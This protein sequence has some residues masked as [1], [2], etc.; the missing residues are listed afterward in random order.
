MGISLNRSNKNLIIIGCYTLL[1]LI[2]TH[3]VTFQLTTHIAG[4]KGEDNLQWRWFLWW[5]KHSILT[6]QNSVTNLSLLYAPTGGEQPF[7][8]ISSFVPSVALPVTL[9][10]GPTASFNLSFLISFILS[11]YTAYLLAYYLTR[12]HLA[13]FIGGLIFAF[14]PARF[15][16]ATGTFLGQLTVYFLPLYVLALLML[17]RRPNWRRVIWAVTI[18][19]CLC[20]TWPLH[21]AYGVVVFTIAFLFWQ[22]FI[23][24]RQP[25]Q[26]AIIKYFAVT[27]GFAFVV[28][29]GAYFPLFQTIL[30]G[31]SDHLNNKDSVKFAVDLLAFISPSN[32]HP[33]LQPLNL[34]PD[35]AT[36]VLADRDD[37][38][39]R[40]AYLGFI[41]LLLALVGLLKYGKKLF[42]W[43]FI[44]FIVMIF[45]LGPILKANGYLYQT[46]IDG[47]VGYVIL[48]YAFI[49]ALPVLS[50]SET[51]GRLNVS[52]M[53]CLAVITAYG[54]TY[55]LTT[56]RSKWHFGLVTLLSLLILLEY[57]TIFPFPT[58]PDIV[59]DFYYQLKQEGQLAPQKIIDLPLEGEPNYNNY[60]MHYQ[61]VHQQAMAGGHFIR[62]PA[63]AVE[64]RAFINQ[65]L[66]PPLP[67]NVF[68]FPD[69]QERLALLN[70]FE[71]TKIVARSW[72]M[73]DEIS[74]SQ[75]AYLSTW[76][77]QPHPQGEVFVFEVPKNKEPPLQITGLLSGDGWQNPAEN[78]IQLQAP[79]DLL[80]YL[81]SAQP[82]QLTL[83]LSLSAP[84][85][86]RYL[87]IDLDGQPA[88]R[89]YLSQEQLTYH[90]PLDLSPG[91]HQFTFRPGETCLQNC[92]PIN[93]SRIALRY[94]EVG[95]SIPISFD[96]QISLIKQSVSNTTAVSSQ[97]ILIYL[98]WQNQKQLSKDYSVFVHLVSSSGRVLTQADYLLGGWLYPTS[99][100]PADHITSVPTLLF[101]PPDTPPGEYQLL[102]GIYQTTT[103]ERL[104][105]DTDSEPKDS[106]FIS[107]II[108]NP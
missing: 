44:A 29:S 16:Y 61:T 8:A 47:Y 68:D 17:A 45:S 11:G 41:P 3:P 1:T 5:F 74:A 33:I 13:G 56:I 85:S 31:Q 103:G 6:L 15:G 81:D 4:F 92:E 24:L 108:I 51:L 21:V 26:R 67:Q 90:I 98:Y 104:L 65:V 64:M 30:Q 89:L 105:A 9:F 78:L 39:E 50:W 60:S 42:L 70:K 93:F 77:G 75:L 101:V 2:L 22:T 76:L 87:A 71:F 35:Y 82:Q 58:E 99:Q 38:Q 100:W 28:I 86:D 72:L 36:R 63:G 88:I 54:V 12:N 73:T 27:F 94:L 62:K 14:Y 55:L 7:Y 57:S 32:Y 10:A 20:L 49:R 18:L 46:N 79:S 107:K 91:I 106:I 83:Q 37:I 97:P 80:L 40:L 96:H 19:V 66:S 84:T 52:V 69:T 34:L 43:L 23:W 102:A 59:P 95:N 48:P 25:Q 53:L